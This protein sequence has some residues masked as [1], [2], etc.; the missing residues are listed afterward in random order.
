[1][2]NK[3]ADLLS[4]ETGCLPI[5]FDCDGLYV[6]FEPEYTKKIAIAG[7]KGIT[8][9]NRDQALALADGLRDIV[10]MYMTEVS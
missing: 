8:Q 6:F 4:L 5:E 9:I 2:N 10:Q 1:M 7:I 3:T